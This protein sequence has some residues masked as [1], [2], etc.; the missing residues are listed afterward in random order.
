MGRIRL[1]QIFP[2]LLPLRIK[3]RKHFFYKKMIKDNNRY[4]QTQEALNS[5]YLIFKEKSLLINN[6][7]GHDIQYQ[8]NKVD[9]L[10]LAAKT[11]DNLIIKPGETF[12]FWHAIKRSYE[13]G[14]YKDGL[15]LVDNKVTTTEAGGLCQISQLL[16]WIFVHSDLE[17]IENYS[18]TS[19]AFYVFREN[20]PMGMEST[21]SEG[22]QD[23]R[24]RNNMTN[25]YQIKITFDE[26]Y[27]TV[28]LFC[29]SKP[30]YV[31]SISEQD[32]Y[33]YEK[34]NTDYYHNKIFK[35]KYY[36]NKLIDSTLFKE[37][38]ILLKYNY[39]DFLNRK[40]DH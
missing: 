11:L 39:R 5:S 16:Y 29:S 37:N 22:W 20:I 12:S 34:N 24:V 14:S 23:L 17:V 3:Q 2:F 21:V 6:D 4:S 7:S 35:E 27:I 25:T 19:Q 26:L 32:Y 33:Y 38:N 10:I 31:Y 15:M 9:N 18:H 36:N 13:L 8:H 28:A 40:D 30:D 1:T